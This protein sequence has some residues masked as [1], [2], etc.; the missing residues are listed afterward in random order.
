MQCSRNRP[1]KGATPNLLRPTRLIQ[2]FTFIPSDSGGPGR[3]WF[4][5][6]PPVG[7]PLAATPYPAYA[8]RLPRSRAALYGLSRSRNTCRR[9]PV[10]VNNLGN[11]WWRLALATG[12][13]NGSFC[14]QK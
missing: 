2:N 11:P 7:L 4:R 3:G 8:I 6:L 14:P 12:I 5:L 9:E 10:Q 13:E 1:Q